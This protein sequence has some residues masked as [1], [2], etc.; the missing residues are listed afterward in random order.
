MYVWSILLRNY[1]ISRTI[2]ASILPTCAD[3]SLATWGVS[4]SP[5]TYLRSRTDHDISYP[6]FR[7]PYLA[8]LHVTGFFLQCKFLRNVFRGRL[9]FHTNRS[10]TVSSS[11][12]MSERF[13]ESALFLYLIPL[14]LVYEV[15]PLGAS[16]VLY[17]RSAYGL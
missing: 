14:V 11:H 3:K 4:P 16:S 12:V 15:L 8:C 17:S 6:L 13:G 1:K 5:L 7:F 9:G 10:L 2:L